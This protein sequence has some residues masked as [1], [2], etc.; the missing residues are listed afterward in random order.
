MPER[1]S[2]HAAFLDRDGTIIHDSDYTRDPDA[3][4]LIDRAAEAM[5]ML[6]AAGYLI[7]VCT[8]QSGIAR[9]LISLAQYHAVRKRLDDLLAAEMVAIA[10]TMVCPHHPDFTGPCDCR[11]PGVALYE[12]AAIVH[13]V[14]LRRSIYIGDRA[15]D[16]APG[17][18]FGGA[19]AL[20]RSPRTDSADLAFARDKNVPIVDSLHEAVS[21]L[22]ALVS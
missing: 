14:D 19:T 6:S 18:A 5:R 3:V 21:M 7:I 10:D 4:I 12:R 20:V 1:R 15:R 22:L 17:L 2:R 16:V 8:N 11:K 9:G 13:D